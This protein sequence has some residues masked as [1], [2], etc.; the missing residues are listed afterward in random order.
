MSSLV[1]AVEILTRG[2]TGQ[3]PLDLRGCLIVVPTRHAGRRLR[4]EL[5]R[6][7]AVHGTAVLSG[8]I[9]TP[10][11]L[12]PLPPEATDDSLVLALLAK[13]LLAQRDKLPALFP[14]TD[15]AW[16][17]P[18]ALGVAAQLQD[19]R[20]QLAEA[21]RAAGDLLPLVPDEERARWA[22]IDQLEKGLLQDIA[23][24][25]RKDPL[26]ARRET[27]RRP[28]DAA[29]ISRVVALFVPD[30][31]ALAIRRLQALPA[32]CAVDLHILAPESEAGR[33]DD[34]GRPL[35]DR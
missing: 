18:F 16:D 31:S 28:A 23:R 33:F 15:V 1:V 24:L 30:F 22:A 9:V 12:V 32:T 8:S 17:F 27:A 19:V 26:A 34:W 13:R 3:G 21:D 25:G 5:A 7:A 11:H 4:A 6:T 10:E 20:R 35:P 2:W 29:G 14:A